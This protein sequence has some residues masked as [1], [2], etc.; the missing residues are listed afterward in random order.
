[1]KVF[2]FV[3][4][5]TGGD[6]LDTIAPFLDTSSLQS[7][8]EKLISG[9]E[10]LLQQKIAIS[11]KLRIVIEQLRDPVHQKKLQN[12]RRDLFNG[13]NPNP[14]EHLLA[15]EIVTGSVRE[16]LIAYLE[17][18]KKSEEFDK[19]FQLFFEG[20]IER[21]SVWLKKIIQ[22]QEALQ[23]GLVLSSQS[24]LNAIPDYVGSNTA[25]FRNKE[26]R[27]EYSLLQYIS[28]IYLKTSPFSTFTNLTYASLSDSGNFL[29]WK[30][31]DMIESH[32]RL[33]NYCLKH[34]KTLL[35]VNKEISSC[36]R[37][38]INP[39]V[40]LKEGYYNYLT[41][42]LNIEAF[43]RIESSPVLE[44]MLEIIY[45]KAHFLMLS[46]IVAA[47]FNEIDASETDLENFVRQLIELGLLEFDWGV[48]GIDPD[49]TTKLIGLLETQEIQEKPLVEQL[50]SMLQG[51]MKFAKEFQYVAPDQR[52]SVLQQSYELFRTGCESIQPVM[53]GINREGVEPYENYVFRHQSNFQFNFRPEQL[54][55]EDTV[56]KCDITMSDYGVNDLMN[57]VELLRKSLRIV[58]PVN[59]EK[60][61]LFEFFKQKYPSDKEVPVLEFYEAYIREF[62]KPRVEAL[63]RFKKTQD[64]NDLPTQVETIKRKN[65]VIEEWCGSLYA[66]L[67]QSNYIENE[68]HISAQQLSEINKSYKY[69]ANAT[70]PGSWGIFAQILPSKDEPVKMV[71][72]K[73]F[74]GYGKLFSRFLH[75]FPNEI[76]NEIVRWNSNYQTDSLFCEINDASYF[77]ANL[78]PPL[79]PFEVSIPGGHSNGD[80]DGK[81][82][83]NELSIRLNQEEENLELIHIPSGK[84]T[85]IFDLGFQSIRGRSPLFSLLQSFSWGDPFN[86]FHLLNTVNR[87]SNKDKSKDEIH[88]LPRIVF[89]RDIILQRKAW[90]I[91]PDQFPQKN[92]QES[93]DRY[94]LKVQQWRK[95]HQIPD[96]IFIRINSGK[97]FKKDDHKPQYIQLSHPLFIRLLGKITSKTKYDIKVEEMLPASGQMNKVNN[98]RLVS[99][100]LLQ[101]YEE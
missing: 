84:R 2:P 27:A 39:T 77:N 15:L 82:P 28:R 34:L 35:S 83:V 88:I 96:E 55:L 13:R 41:N 66:D 24:L 31:N 79:M 3:L 74:V 99:E 81:I 60:E 51:L 9:Y 50:L 8:T 23:K 73:T 97:E 78:H 101:W 85:F 11:E 37:I 70:S 52:S 40:E 17:L 59:Y 14:K 58:S 25:S 100:F 19:Q 16:E 10:I 57:K 71:I 94:Y 33:N 86:T 80:P 20:Q 56:R 98:K 92:S 75:V 89:E 54:F 42:H 63:D 93:D 38:T 72:N 6:Y 91:P 95:K 4:I 48:S 36:L 64:E 44:R 43:Q 7:E 65:Q 90:I 22:E 45:E 12:F 61:Y 68:F 18:K 62:K 69:E 30:S 29:H 49:W 32:I 87:F 5:R 1:M 26:L 46:E 76:E 53:A 21:V 67:S 47:L